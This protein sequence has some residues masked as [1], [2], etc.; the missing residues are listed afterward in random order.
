MRHP[1]GD[2]ENGMVYCSECRE[3]WHECRCKKT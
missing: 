1:I 3:L 2:H